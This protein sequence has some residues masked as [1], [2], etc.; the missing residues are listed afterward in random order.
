ML[1]TLAASPQVEER[2]L[3]ITTLRTLA[4]DGSCPNERTC[5]SVHVLDTYPERRYLIVRREI[6]PTVLAAFAHLVAEDEHL[7]WVPDTLFPE[8][9]A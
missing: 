9:T 6:D 5:P 3:K 7:G 8:I 4:G 1:R 2:L